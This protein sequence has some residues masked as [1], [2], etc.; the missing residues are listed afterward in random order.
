MPV[1]RPL[2]ARSGFS[3]Y[4]FLLTLDLIG[5]SSSTELE[6][7]AEDDPCLQEGSGECSA[8]WLQLKAR[9]KGVKSFVWL[10]DIHAD[11]YYGTDLQ[12]CRNTSTSEHANG[13]LTCDPPFDLFK[14]AAAAAAA[15]APSA[16]F[17]LFTGDFVRHKQ[18]L[19]PDP[20]SN[21]THIIERVSSEVAAAF[22]ELVRKSRI[23]I[24]ALGNDDSPA[25]YELN[26]TTENASNPWL[27]NAAEAMTKGGV[28]GHQFNTSAYNYGGY[29]AQQQGPLTILTINTII[30]CVNHVPKSDPLPDDPFFQF[31]WMKQQLEKA[32]ELK[33]PV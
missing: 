11:P 12:Q 28:L 18:D 29:F 31:R 2:S 15:A 32:A 26:L 6:G 21:V 16:E 24:G 13:M 30:Y 23:V 20:Y 25:N 1:G 7:F 33:R 4:L 3:A 5:T 22:P 19:M 14:S 27:R 9:R 10:S 17:V 8:S